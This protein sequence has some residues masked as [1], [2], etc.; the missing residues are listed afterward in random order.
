MNLSELKLDDLQLFIT[1]ADSQSI[2]AAAEH[3]QTNTS[4]LSRRLKKLEETLGARLLDRTT[5]SQH[6]TEAGK[7]FYQHCQ[8][9]LKS[10]DQVSRQINDQQD[11]LEG[12]ISIYAPAE[13][14]RYWI[15]ELVVE[16]SRQYPKLR[17]EFVSGA[18]KP[19]LLE[20]NIDII[21]HV[22]EPADSSFVARKVNVVTT[23]YYASPDY[24]AKRGQPKHPME[25]KS[26]DCIVEIDHDRTPRPWRIRDGDVTT[27]IKVTDR[28]CS[29]SADLCRVL[30]EQGQGIAM[31]PDFIA[32][33]SQENGKLV[34]LFGDRR[35]IPHNVYALYASRNYLPR[36]T[37]VFL[38]FL[39]DNIPKEI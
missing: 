26:H 14:F 32:K 18:D 35:G 19:N 8:L 29:D 25:M 9:V 5:R 23:S 17:I 38:D 34:K 7:L 24:L 12:R 30:A 37:Q 22:N 4:T 13:L 31:L 1:V 11:A 36:K 20:D 33:E 16:F 28:Y 39:I 2:T 3:L 6:I 10:L 15:K 27:T 21:L